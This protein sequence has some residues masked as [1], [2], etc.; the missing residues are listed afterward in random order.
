MDGTEILALG[1]GVTP[2]WRLLDQRLDT[3]Q[4]PYVLEIRL[5][6]KRGARFPC[7]D[8]GKACKAHD[9]RQFTWRHLN[10]SSITVRSRP[11]FHAPTARNTGSNE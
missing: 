5:G 1:L 8:C 9:F 7:P 4:R 10:F 3:G 6:A 11:R 2:P